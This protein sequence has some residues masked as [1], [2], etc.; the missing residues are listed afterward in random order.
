MNELVLGANFEMQISEVLRTVVG[1]GAI[2]LMSLVRIED[3]ED[4]FY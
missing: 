2:V 3:S 1:N 4:F